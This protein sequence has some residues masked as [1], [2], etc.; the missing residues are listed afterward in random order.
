MLLTRDALLNRK[1]WANNIY[2]AFAI[3]DHD[4]LIFQVKRFRWLV[5]GNL[6]GQNKRFHIF[7]KAHSHAVK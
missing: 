7:L 6:Y 3:I 2:N 4:I 5:L 1:C